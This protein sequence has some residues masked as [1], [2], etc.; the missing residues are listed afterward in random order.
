MATFPKP[1]NSL[2]F[3]SLIRTQKG[4]SLMALIQ[5]T[6]HAKRSIS[7][8]SDAKVEIAKRLKD[9]Y[10][11]YRDNLKGKDSGSGTYSGT[12]D[13]FE[14]QYTLGHEC[15]IWLNS[16]LDL[17]PYA[18]A[19]AEGRMT[20]RK[21]LDCVLINYIQPVNG[22]CVHPLFSILSF[23]VEHNTNK[24][25]RSELDS[26]FTDPSGEN[27]NALCWILNSTDF[28]VYQEKTLTY[29]SKQYK[30]SELMAMCNTEYVGKE[31]YIK[32]QAEL[33]DE[34]KY[35]AY[36]LKKPRKIEIPNHVEQEEPNQIENEELERGDLY[37]KE[38]FLKEVFIDAKEYEDIKNLLMYKHNIVLQGAP[39]VGKTFM[40]KKLAYSIIG[41]VAKDQVS[42]IQFHQSYS[43][44]D[45]I[46]GYKPDGDGF[47]LKPGV[48]YSFCKKAEK[49]SKEKF[50]FIIDEINRGNL[51]KI[52]GE[53]MMLIEGDKRNEYVRLAYRNEE[54]FHVPENVYLIGMMNTA[55]RSL[56]LIDYAL[57]RRFS[58]C[59][60]EPA[61]GKDSFKEYLKERVGLSADMEARINK[62]LSEVNGY[63]ANEAISG[64]GKGFCI[65][66]SYFCNPPI[67]GQN[68]NQWYD[69]IIKYEIAPLLNEYWWDDKSKVDDCIEKLGK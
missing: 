30:I 41:N 18:V 13:Q 47:K 40:A 21:Y 10:N 43:Y 23:M 31:G 25:A 34:D 28:F 17:N 27:I 68:E 33:S 55:D 22:S 49:Y 62:N 6:Y 4:E 35:N 32:A 58:F 1:H 39:G 65:G 5:A 42:V 64:L 56:A 2:Y 45:F 9:A 3:D 26:V 59:E 61:F 29:I 44:E 66:H 67:D 63:I 7:N 38:D 36:I 24:I 20:I 52:F 19:V 15:A 14:S 60:I 54:E 69:T 16:D 50:F 53:L 51:S 12:Y 48:F 37:T 46:M 57:R 11:L 8:K